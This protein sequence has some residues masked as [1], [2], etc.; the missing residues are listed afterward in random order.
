M[1]Q[2]N[3]FD[4]L[5][6][7][8]AVVTAAGSL[9]GPMRTARAGG[10]ATIAAGGASWYIRN[11]GSGPGTAPFLTPP[12][13][14]GGTR[15]ERATKEP[16]AP[17]GTGNGCAMNI[18]SASTATQSDAYDGFFLMAVNGTQYRDPDGVFTTT[19]TSVSGSPTTIAGL[20]VS[21][22]Y[23]FFAS[24]PVVRAIYTYQNA[25]AAPITVT[26][27]MGY[28]VGSD[29]A[30]I[31]QATSDG[32]LLVETNDAWQVSSEGNPS[33]DPV[34]TLS[35]FGAGG[36]IGVTSSTV[37][38]AT[39]PVEEDQI[40]NYTL[41]VPAN[42][43]R[44]LM[45]FSRVDPTIAAATAAAPTFNTLASVQA[46]GF[47]AGL[48]PAQLGEIANWSPAGPVG[49]VSFVSR[50][51]TLGDWGRIAMI[52]ALGGLAFVATRRLRN[53]GTR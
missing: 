5:R 47:T 23:Q 6:L 26:V 20:T 17:A 29:S 50:V 30:T 28:N 16:G 14:G 10:S 8:A 4:R 42:A 31:V 25:T 9:F 24:A 32:D 40:D 45:F 33:T 11:S 12:C 13:V 2:G 19:A 35:R 3:G 15:P 48:T 36:A 52:L 18:T 44:R 22:D 7:A 38:V 43:T 37:V 41:T 46:A 51:P 34:V 27:A 49:G 39:T 1:K 21:G 53:P